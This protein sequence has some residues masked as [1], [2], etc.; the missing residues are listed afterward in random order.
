MNIAVIG[1][2][3]GIG[4]EITQTIVSEHLLQHDQTLTLVGNPEGNSSRSLYG[5][6]VDLMDA[7]AEICP[8]IEVVFSPDDIQS[9][10]IVMAGGATLDA[11]KSQTSRD[12]V[13]QMNFP[14]FDSYAEA[15]KK[16]GHGHEIVICVSNP[17]ELAVAAFA[18]HLGRSVWAPF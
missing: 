6:S 13:A 10:L 17:N 12:S 16:N 18:H 7:Y 1:A 11:S 8:N 3:G 9:D 5:Y 15:I 14:V 4:R 2:G